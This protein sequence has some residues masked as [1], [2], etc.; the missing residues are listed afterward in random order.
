MLRAVQGGLHPALLAVALPQTPF[1]LPSHCGD[2]YAAS[3]YFSN[4]RQSKKAKKKFMLPMCCFYYNV[5]YQKG[6]WED[7]Q[8]G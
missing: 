8:Q 4:H 7:D 5:N 3:G 6:V 2:G 1:G